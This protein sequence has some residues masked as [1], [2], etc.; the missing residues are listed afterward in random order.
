MAR[1]K[2]W[3]SAV[4]FEITLLALKEEMTLNEICRR[5]GVSPSQ[6]HLWKKQLLEQG[7]NIFNKNDKKKSSMTEELER[8]QS[9]L[10]EKIGQLTVERDFLKKSWNK[11]QRNGEED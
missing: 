3:S 1:N 7:A 6:I 9:K 11:L 10:Y 2:K 5:Y 4:K 8:K